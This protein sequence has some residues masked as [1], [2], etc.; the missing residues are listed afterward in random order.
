MCG[1]SAWG[2]LKGTELANLYVDTLAETQDHAQR[3]IRRI[4]NL[5]PDPGSP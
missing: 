5:E 1:K 2:N 4:S 3:G